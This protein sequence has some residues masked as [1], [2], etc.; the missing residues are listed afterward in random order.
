MDI[1]KVLLQPIPDFSLA[2]TLKPGYREHAL[3]TSVGSHDDEPLVAIEDYGIAG[4]SYYSRPNNA[5]SDPVPGVEPQVLVRRS[6][7]EK[8]AA[9][10]Y[11]L[12]KSGVASELL[13]GPVELYVD[14]GYRSPELQQKLYE[15]IFPYL[16][17]QQYPDWS[18]ERVL[19]RRDELSASPPEDGA[20]SPHATGA[21][22][23]VRLRYQNPELGHI[24]GSGVPMGQGSADTSAL[25][26]PD[27]FEHLK[28]LTPEQKAFRDN[29][30]VFYWIMKGGLLGDDTGFVVNPTEWWHW[31]FGDQMWARLTQSPEAFYGQARA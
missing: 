6:I 17:S 10:N 31:S 2:R 21:A 15:E 11:E 24:D 27:Y 20:P 8:L 25:A 1:R 30:R 29:R 16:I 9:I 26:S 14:E 23:D 13:G 5:T 12:Q 28:S 19:K 3:L 4:Q 7:A 18:R 22:I